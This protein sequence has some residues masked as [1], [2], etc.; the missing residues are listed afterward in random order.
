MNEITIDPK[1]QF[2][3]P[4][5]AGTGIKTEVVASRFK[6]GELIRDLALDYGRLSKRE[7]EAAIRYEMNK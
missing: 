2:G 5:I 6:A 3:S 7:I 4:C 1:V